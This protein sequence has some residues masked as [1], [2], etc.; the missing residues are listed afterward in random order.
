[1]GFSRQE[2]WS[3]YLFPSPGDLA[4]PGIEPKSSAV[5]SDSLPPEPPGKPTGGFI[6]LLIVH[7]LDYSHYTIS[8]EIGRLIPP[9]V[10]FFSENISCPIRFALP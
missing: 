1:M 7:S 6:P 9:S 10:V 2:Y 4:D 8:L 5:Q 3:G